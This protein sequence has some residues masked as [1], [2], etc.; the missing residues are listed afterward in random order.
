MKSFPTFFWLLIGLFA[1][2]PAEALALPPG[3]LATA[4]A[5]SAIGVADGM[6]YFVTDFSWPEQGS[7]TRIMVMPLSGGTPSVVA[8]GLHRITAFVLAPHHLY[9]KTMAG[10]VQRVPRRGGVVETLAVVEASTTDFEGLAVTSSE[11]SVFF[12]REG[13]PGK[14][15]GSFGGRP[16]LNIPGSVH[17][18]DLVR[19]RKPVTATL[20]SGSS[21][22]HGLALGP[23][24]VYFVSY[25][26]IHRV[27]QAGGATVL[28]DPVPNGTRGVSSDDSAL[29]W[30]TWDGDVDRLLRHPFGGGVSSPIFS[31]RRLGFGSSI[32][33]GEGRLVWQASDDKAAYMLTMPALG[34]PVTLLATSMLDTSPVIAG[35]DA[36]W[37]ELG[38]KREEGRPATAKSDV[39]RFIRRAPLT[40]EGCGSRECPPG[41]RCMTGVCTLIPD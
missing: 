6:L 30:G 2:L 29:Y 15:V 35:D 19:S 34:G 38:A 31:S 14:G 17:R 25:D 8:T 27:S 10:E 32:A 4:R 9:W 26:G 13:P 33:V 11:T 22:A 20:F 1:F 23:G 5:H 18:I 40:G 24:V 7:G 3:T 16:R 37:A 36:Y 21:G 39:P 28:V 12:T 41:F